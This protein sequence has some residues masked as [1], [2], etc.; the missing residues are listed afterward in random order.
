MRYLY[1][2][3]SE[4]R[5]DF[6]EA[7]LA[8]TPKVFAVGC[9][10][11]LEITATEKYFGGIQ[12]WLARFE[13]LRMLYESEVAIEGVVVDRPE[14]GMALSPGQKRIL[15]LPQG[16]TQEI[17]FKK[18][19]SALF[20]CGDPSTLQEEQKDREKLILFMK[21]MGLGTIADFAALSAPSLQRRFGK[22]ALHL[23]DW[24][25]GTR[26]LCLP[27]FEP[28]PR[29][30]ELL[31]TEEAPHQ[32]ALVYLMGATLHRMEARL[33]GRS[34]LAKKLTFTFHLENGARKKDL[35]LSEPSRN[36][37]S[38]LKLFS[39]WLQGLT[40]D[41]PLKKMG[42]E[43]TE[44]T[45]EG[46]R[47]LHLFDDEETRQQDL[48]NY[49]GRLRSRLGKE[50]AG[51]VQLKESHL[52]E[53]AWEMVDHPVLPAPQREF[54]PQR[55]LYLFSPR[56]F[57]FDPSLWRLSPSEK[58]TTSWWSGEPP[59]QYYV[60]EGPGGEKMWLFETQNRWFLH[61]EFY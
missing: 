3:M 35:L 53:K 45:P 31:D 6:A 26:S 4:P 58:L 20:F 1:L 23:H 36:S 41:S 29:L 2:K 8:L 52:P 21:K 33:L 13:T 56:P 15:L 32:E 59:R 51:F 37:Q 14:W 27:I 18:N 24:V 25:L 9:H 19:I 38:L 11:Y 47:Q 40:W 16:Q 50:Q 55:P 28:D 22:P 46:S 49:L 39:E 5:P 57:P 44:S 34:V 48:L 61:G 7:C 12:G 30:R 43:V 54:Y 10:L 60:A 17:L 42:V